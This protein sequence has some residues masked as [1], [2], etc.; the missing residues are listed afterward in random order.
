MAGKVTALRM[1]KR[2]KDWV[3]VFVDGKYVFALP[4][5]KAAGLHSGQYLSDEEIAK[6]RKVQANEK[7]YEQAVRLLGN[8]PRSR[9]EIR[10][11]LRKKK[12][13]PEAIESVIQRLDAAGYLDDEAFARFWVENRL[14]FSP[15]GR[16]ALRYELR[17]KGVPGD[18]IK[19]VLENLLEGENEEESALDVATVYARRW[20]GT[21]YQSFRRKIGGVLSRRGYDYSII[22]SVVRRLWNQRSETPEDDE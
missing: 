11:H 17:Q 1:Q 16:R 5:V 20:K 22:Q 10:Q 3:N 18:T 2:R 7:A 19:Q 6:W 15:R 21:D 8:R 14:Q 9:Y 12:V 4:D 13:A